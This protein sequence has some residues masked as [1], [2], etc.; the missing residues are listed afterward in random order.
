MVVVVVVVAVTVSAFDYAFVLDEG[1]AAG[2]AG[3]DEVGVSLPLDDFCRFVAGGGFVASIIVRMRRWA[4]CR[5][6][7]NN[8][9]REI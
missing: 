5:R 3:A 8:G 6:R 4:D 9:E 7:E 2:V 1:G